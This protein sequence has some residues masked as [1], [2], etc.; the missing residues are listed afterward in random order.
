LR[1]IVLTFLLFFLLVEISDSQVIIFERLSNSDPRNNENIFT[2]S[3]RIK[4]DLNGIWRARFGDNNIGNLNIPFCT[5]FRDDILL[6][7]DITI[8]DSVLSNYNFLFYCEG[9]NYDSEVKINDAIISRNSGGNKLIITEIRDNLLQGNNKIVIRITNNT[10]NSSTYPLSNQVNY[11]KNYTGILSNI[12]LYAV[13]KIYLSEILSDYSIEPNNMVNFRNQIRINTFNIDSIALENVSFNVITELLK[14]SD[15]TKVYESQKFKIEPK[16]YQNYNVINESVLK[17]IEFWSPEKPVLYLVRTVIMREND[18]IDEYITETGFVNKSISGNV[19]LINEQKYKIHGI[20]YFEDQPKY[21]TALEYSRTEKDLH[22]IKLN[23]FNCIRIPGKAAHPFIIRIAQRIGLF[24]FEEIPFNEISENLL[25]TEKYRKGAAEY[26]ESVIKRDKNSPA[27]LFWGIGNNFDVLHKSSEIYANEIIEKLTSLD[28]RGFYYT[29]RSLRNDLVSNLI[30]VRGYN[31]TGSDVNLFK[32]NLVKLDG[33]KFNIITSFGI[34]TVNSNRNGYGD[35]NSEESQA[36]FI[37]DVLNAVQGY[38]VSFISSFAD[39]HSESPLLNGKNDNIY[40]KTDGIFTYDRYPK[41]AAEIIKRYLNNQG[42]QKIPEGN[43]SS[44]DQISHNLIMI[45]SITFLLFFI[46]TVSRIKYFKDNLFKC[47]FT[48]RNFY[49]TLREQS[50]IPLFQ[51]ILIIFYLNLSIGLYISSVLYFLVNNQ[52]FDLLLSR[53]VTNDVFKNYSIIILR[54]PALLVLFCSMTALLS[55]FIILLLAKIT[56]TAGKIHTR[57]RNLMTI[58]TWSF[59]PLLSLLPVSIFLGRFLEFDRVFL[60]YTVYFIAVIIAFTL[61]KLI[62]GIRNVFEL[63]YFRTYLTG[64][65][66]LFL[67]AG[68]LY[69]YFEVYKSLFEVIKLIKSYS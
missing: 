42:F 60:S 65:L 63:N 50:S 36:K 64:T 22:L 12:G 38:P 61:L 20:N 21:G 35:P 57:S 23:G 11:S 45:I 67:V 16:S 51:N 58:V 59:V 18:V 6:E 56:L 5:D 46:L 1:T 29:T 34:P 3:K 44:V 24:V 4:I 26:L 69:F 8:P 13:P 25:E 62:N 7:K 30:N 33:K 19:L 48:P 28:N 9:I 47:I 43:I 54:N 27:V 39:Y 40:L 14:K 49:Y 10:D 17:N 52:D 2:S 15:S 37:T 32:E 31:F 53:I 66:L 68:I 55:F 41:Y